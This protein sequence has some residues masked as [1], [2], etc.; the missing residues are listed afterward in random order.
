MSRAVMILAFVTAS[1]ALNTAA[2]PAVHAK[3][4]T[5]ERQ[6][7][8]DPDHRRA[9]GAWDDSGYGPP[10]IEDVIAGSPRWREEAGEKEE[11]EHRRSP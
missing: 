8:V 3:S 7:Q 4:T 11:R 10:W 6:R 5:S 1:C 9:W 2:R